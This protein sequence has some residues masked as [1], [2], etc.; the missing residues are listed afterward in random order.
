MK[1]HLRNYKK[2]LC[3]GL[4]VATFAALGVPG[5]SVFAQDSDALAKAA[6]NPIA[7]MI[8]LPLQ[9]NTN[10]NAGPKSQT[11]NVLNIQP[12]YP[13]NLN[14]EW[15]LIT[16]TIIPIIS[17]PD[18]GVPSAERTNGIGDLQFSAFFSPKKP[19]PSGWTWGVGPVLQLPTATNDVLG[20]GKWG[21]G[22]TAVALHI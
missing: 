19:T 16:R 10:L 18:F 22:P 11:Q 15:N 6:R 3:K 7:D 21:L 12:V 9:N 1:Q 20:Q 2:F 13:V 4:T 5:E 8:S 17:Q 14:P